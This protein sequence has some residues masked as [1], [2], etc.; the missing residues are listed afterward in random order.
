M[1][2]NYYDVLKGTVSQDF[3]PPCQSTIP[4]SLIITLNNCVRSRSLRQNISARSKL[5]SNILELVNY[6]G[7]RLIREP[8]SLIYIFK[9][10][11]RGTWIGPRSLRGASL[12]TATSASWSFLHAKQKFTFAI[13]AKI[14][15]F[16]IGLILKILRRLTS[17][18]YSSW[19]DLDSWVNL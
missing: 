6:G 8:V 1:V 13:P 3:Q 2:Q 4:R 18:R 9:I 14:K 19:M 16:T 12:T 5:Y 17:A 10:R 11:C 7:S 15:R